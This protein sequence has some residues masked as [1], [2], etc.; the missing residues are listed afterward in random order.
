[1]DE[2][3]Y[4]QNRLLKV[5]NMVEVAILRT[6]LPFVVN[7]RPLVVETFHSGYLDLK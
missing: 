4:I 5:R 7:I 6:F 2:E 1:M 3:S